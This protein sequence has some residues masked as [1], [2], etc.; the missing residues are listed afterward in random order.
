MTSKDEIENRIRTK[1]EKEINNQKALEKEETLHGV[2]LI[3]I[4]IFRE[5]K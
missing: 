2:Y 4:M 5:K 1:I 3:L